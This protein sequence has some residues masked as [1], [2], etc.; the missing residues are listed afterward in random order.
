MRS[1]EAGMRG[2]I[3]KQGACPCPFGVGSADT[4]NCSSV[5]KSTQELG[6][7]LPIP[8]LMLCTEA[9]TKPGM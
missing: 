9:E 2:T 3:V 7:A 1:R 4:L 5:P 8:I 6:A